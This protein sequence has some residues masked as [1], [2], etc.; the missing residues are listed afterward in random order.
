MDGLCSPE[1]SG[2]PAGVAWSPSS[3]LAALF[4]LFTDHI[5]A[6][7]SALSSTHPRFILALYGPSL[8]G[9]FLVWR[10]Y[11]VKGLG[12]Y[13]RRLT[14]LPASSYGSDRPC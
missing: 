14:S 7:F 11:G 9:V 1:G 13:L 6:V 8:A 10:H 3:G 5:E 2:R 4:V 12:S